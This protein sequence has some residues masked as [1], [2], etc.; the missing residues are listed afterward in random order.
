MIEN[1]LK[2]LEHEEER[3]IKKINETKRRTDQFLKARM[4]HEQV[5]SFKLTNLIFLRN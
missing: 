2:R 1:R 3:A 4:L 5:L